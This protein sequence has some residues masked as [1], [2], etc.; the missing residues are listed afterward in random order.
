M[1]YPPKTME[2]KSRVQMVEMKLDII[3][4]RYLPKY[5]LIT[6]LKQQQ[7]QNSRFIVDTTGRYL[8]I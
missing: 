6:K 5:L 4:S 3:V 1:G 2:D 7:N 8:L